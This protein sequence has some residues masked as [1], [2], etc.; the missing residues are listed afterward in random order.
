MA[1]R[2]M[3]QNASNDPDYV[4]PEKYTHSLKALPDLAH[5]SI[6]EF[7]PLLLLE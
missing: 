4:P 1:R 6:P 7:K 3:A 2:K 5:L